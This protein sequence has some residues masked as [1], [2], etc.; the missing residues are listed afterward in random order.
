MILC[1]EIKL[2]NEMLH[3]SMA[4]L[5]TAQL[6]IGGALKLETSI[7]Y[8]C[9]RG[10]MLRRLLLG[11]LSRSM[12]IIIISNISFLV[13]CGFPSL[14]KLLQDGGFDT[15]ARVARVIGNFHS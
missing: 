14:V 3:Y 15:V 2:I 9:P 11:G 12:Y 5:H 8:T 6:H 4:D 1:H 13:D 10:L 7:Q